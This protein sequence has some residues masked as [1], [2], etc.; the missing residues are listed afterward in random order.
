[1]DGVCPIC[2][3]ELV[4]MGTLGNTP[5]YNCLDCGAWSS[6]EII[7]TEMEELYEEDTY[8]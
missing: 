3:G 8:E 2:Y 5:H 4:Y 6:L 1:M 7:D